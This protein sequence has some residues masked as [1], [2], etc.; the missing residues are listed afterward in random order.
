MHSIVPDGGVRDPWDYEI[1]KFAAVC[2]KVAQLRSENKIETK[3]S[4]DI[5]NH[6]KNV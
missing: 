6:Y 4:M 5:F 2:Q 3:T 1:S